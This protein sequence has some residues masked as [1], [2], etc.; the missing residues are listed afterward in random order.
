[1]D[2]IGLYSGAE[3]ASPAGIINYDLGFSDGAAGRLIVAAN[4]FIA[5]KC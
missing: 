1:M 3:N 4:P 5:E 2:N